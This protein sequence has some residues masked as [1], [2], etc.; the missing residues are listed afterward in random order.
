MKL[1]KTVSVLVVVGMLACLGAG[2][3]KPTAK[4]VGSSSTATSTESET[5]ST[6]D[7]SV[8]SGVTSGTSTVTSGTNAASGTTGNSG[9]S[10]SKSGTGAHSASGL[11]TR[12]PGIGRITGDTSIDLKGAAVTI[13]NWYGF[14]KDPGTDDEGKRQIAL[15]DQIEKTYNCKLNWVDSSDI[16]SIKSSVLAGRPKL[17]FCCLGAGLMYDFYSANCLTN[18]KTLKTIH[19][20]DTTRYDSDTIANIDGGKYGLVPTKIS[21]LKRCMNATLT[22]DFSLTAQAGHPASEIYGWI[23]NNQWNWANFEKVCQDVAKKVPGA[24]GLDEHGTK[25]YGTVNMDM[26]FYQA[27]LWSD[28]TDWV[29]KSGKNFAFTGGSTNAMKVL[30]QYTKWCNSKTGFIKYQDSDIYN[31][32]NAGKSAFIPDIYLYTSIGLPTNRQVGEVW[33]PMGP[34][35]KKYVSLSMS[36]GWICIMKNIKNPQ[37]MGAIYE[38]CCT[39]LYTNEESRQ[40]CLQAT[41][42]DN[43]LTDSINVH[44]AIFDDPDCAPC[45]TSINAQTAHLDIATSSTDKNLG[46]LN[47]VYKV[48][49]GQMT[50]QQAV[51]TFT[52][53]CNSVLATTFN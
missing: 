49:Q 6:G 19:P 50:A 31:N 24:Y 12:I 20:N 17:N 32:F 48:S 7:S 14:Q 42:T 8:T 43:T 22:C 36:N 53:R 46:W 23:K 1:S 2:C 39:P 11:A 21:W 33:Y 41:E 4:N 9:G 40:Q 51:S 47:Y 18:L 25:R 45:A 37:A 34:D 28:N 10:A 13:G 35:A 27:M 3:N 44:M 52:S 5:G 16:A 38:A 29:G 30:N 15:N 26:L